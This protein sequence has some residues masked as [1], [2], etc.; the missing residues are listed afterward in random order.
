MWV[1]IKRPPLHI[2]TLLSGS[3]L[4]GDH[5][6]GR[7]TDHRKRTITKYDSGNSHVIDPDNRRKARGFVAHHVGENGLSVEGA[8]VLNSDFSTQIAAFTTK[9]SVEVA[10]GGLSQQLNDNTAP[11]RPLSMNGTNGRASASP[12]PCA[13][14]AAVGPP[15]VRVLR[16]TVATPI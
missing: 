2:T 10:K 6:Q 11:P 14:V 13:S 4:G 16:V 1:R 5:L 9:L 12:A 7:I 15:G 3:C 8:E